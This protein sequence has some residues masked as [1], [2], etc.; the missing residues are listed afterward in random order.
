MACLH[1]A[2]PAFSPS[3]PFRPNLPV[4]RR[5]VLPLAIPFHCRLQQG[6]GDSNGEEP[7][8]S[9]FMKELKR[10]GVTPSSLLEDTEKAF[11]RQSKEDVAA[12]EENGGEPGRGRS[13]R[14]GVASAEY[15][16]GALR[17]REVSM[18]LN[19]EG[20]EGLIPRAKLL[21]TIGGTFFLGF[22]P[23]ILITVSAFAALYFYFGPTFVHD[24][25]KISASPPP[26]IEP[27]ELLKD[28]RISEL[29][30]NVK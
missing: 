19:S 12:E 9:L 23:L 10:R 1:I 30:P 7:P 18:A 8:E 6:N 25:S 28:E 27:Y 17:Q 20:I 24:A 13:K 26:Y 14:N 21:L 22:W 16:K 11:Y 5:A 15:E 3:I 4:R 2:R 29:A